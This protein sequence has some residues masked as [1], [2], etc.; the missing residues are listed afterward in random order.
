MSVFLKIANTQIGRATLSLFIYVVFSIIGIEVFYAAS[1]LL[2]PSDRMF[3][4]LPLDSI[5]TA[6]ILIYQNPWSAASPQLQFLLYFFWL[7]FWCVAIYLR[8]LSVQRRSRNWYASW[9]VVT[10]ISVF[11]SIVV[12]VVFGSRGPENWNI[13]FGVLWINL[14][15]SFLTFLVP[16]KFLSFQTTSSV[17][18]D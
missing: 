14:F 3:E 12:S 16:I 10:S 7:V 6:H 11:M 17:L 5:V 13:A 1:M 2:S 15:Y 18:E 8:I 4:L 9:W